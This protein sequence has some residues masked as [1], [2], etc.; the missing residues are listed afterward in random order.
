MFLPCSFVSVQ[1][2]YEISS[3]VRPSVTPA[4]FLLVGTPAPTV[5]NGETPAPTVVGG[6]T[7][8][9]AEINPTT[10]APM[11]VVTGSG[12]LI[13]CFADTNGARIMTLTLSQTPMG[14]EVRESEKQQ[15]ASSKQAK[16]SMSFARIYLFFRVETLLLASCVMRGRVFQG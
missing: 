12:T 15:R 11:E 2:I 13:G 3:S 8:A 1:Q 9:P 6:E 4:P 10:P 14:S 16:A 7:P 5:A